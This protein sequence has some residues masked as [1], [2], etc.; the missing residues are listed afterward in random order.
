MEKKYIT[1]FSRN[2]CNALIQRGFN[3]VEV[4]QDNRYPAQTVFFF[5]NSEEIRAAVEEIQRE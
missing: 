2:M 4:K 1:I 3:V 5:K